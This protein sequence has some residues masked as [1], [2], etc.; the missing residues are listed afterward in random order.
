MLDIVIIM[1]EKQDAF[2][3]TSEFKLSSQKKR[4]WIG[5]F[6]ALVNPIFADLILG[7]AFISERSMK[8]QGQIITWFSV[9][10]GV[11]SILLTIVLAPE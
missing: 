6:I 5:M 2:Y 4:F 3:S 10:W 1:S 7:I 8:K 11:L 9:I